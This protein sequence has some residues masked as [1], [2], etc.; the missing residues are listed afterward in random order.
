MCDRQASAEIEVTPEMIQA[1]ANV[2]E[3]LAEDMGITAAGGHVSRLSWEIFAERFFR[4]TLVAGSR[5]Q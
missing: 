1:G 4:D 5:G 3:R 2:A